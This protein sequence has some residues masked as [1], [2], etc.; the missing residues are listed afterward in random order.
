MT[1]EE[2][3]NAPLLA[4]AEPRLA[5]LWNV[6]LLDDDDHSY[7]YVIEMLGRLFGHS[8]TRAYQMACD[9]DNAGRVILETVV[10]ERA[11]FK[12]DQ[13]HAYGADWRIEHCAGSMSALLEPVEC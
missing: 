4:P 7:A 11:E 13:V 6:V 3:S 12:R 2:H 10:Y 1:H 5:P 9:V 8:R